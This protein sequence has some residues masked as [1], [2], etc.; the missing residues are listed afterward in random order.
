MVFVVS[1]TKT[2]GS[3]SLV[4]V[5][6]LLTKTL[7]HTQMTPQCRNPGS[8]PHAESRP[9]IRL[10]SFA[11]II[12]V[13]D[14]INPRF[15]QDPPPSTARFLLWQK[16]P[17][18]EANKGPRGLPVVLP[19]T[20]EARAAKQRRWPVRATGGSGVRLHTFSASPRIREE[21]TT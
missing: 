17:Q 6:P 7:K 1:W 11:E 3:I 16:Y 5:T 8:H 14:A 9:A 10:G 15:D 18:F 21:T 13:P 2:G 19:G 4:E 20:Y 12:G